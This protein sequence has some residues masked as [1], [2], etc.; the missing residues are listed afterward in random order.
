MRR[1]GAW[2]LSVA[3][4][5]GAGSVW[6]GEELGG[7]GPPPPSSSGNWIGRWFKPGGPAAEKKPAPEPEKPAPEKKPVPQHRPSVAEEATALRHREEA[8][9]FRRLKVCDKL[10]E[11]ADLTNDTALQRRADELEARAWDVYTQRTAHLPA[12]QAVFQSDVQTLKKHLGPGAAAAEPPAGGARPDSARVS[13][14]SAE[15]GK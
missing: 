4:W 8:K 13:R 6:A 12:S 7:G 5:V 11:I 1:L 15:E 9:Y 10:R 2:G 3:L 14:P